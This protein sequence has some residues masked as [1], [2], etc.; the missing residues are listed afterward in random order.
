MARKRPNGRRCSFESLEDRRVLAGNVTAVIS[1]G[2]LVITGD[3]DDNG[4][5]IVPTAVANQVTITGTTVGT[6]TSVNNAGSN[7]TVTLSFTGKLIVN[8]KDGDDNVFIGDVTGTN[9]LTSTGLE[10][11]MGDGD[12]DLT[13][14]SNSVNGKTKID[15]GDGDDTM[16]FTNSEVTGNAKFKGGRGDNSPMT[17]DTAVFDSNVKIK[18]GKHQNASS[19]LTVTNTQVTG[20]AAIT[21]TRGVDDVTLGLDTFG[22][23]R[24]KLRGDDDLLTVNTVNVN[25]ST[26]L[27]G[28]SGDNTLTQLG[29]NDLGVLKVK[30]FS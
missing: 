17:I 8:M 4:I 6:A 10:V 11:K 12:D 16:N 13:V 18:L 28:G 23:L 5:E 26:D 22:K 20:K 24:V 29:T 14:D 3:D 7:N 21:G 15:L 30:N 25:T 19:L 1:H 2:N 27:N 9:I